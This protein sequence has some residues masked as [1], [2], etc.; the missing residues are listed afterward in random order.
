MLRTEDEK[1]TLAADYPSHLGDYE[2]ST[3]TES[4]YYITAE[5]TADSVGPSPGHFTLGD[6]HRYGQY[7]NTALL[8]GRVF[9]KVYE[10]AVSRRKEVRI[11]KLLTDRG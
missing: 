6:G 4:G 3:E 11:Y 5:L 1:S 2:H 9:Y 7:V 8:K 10:R